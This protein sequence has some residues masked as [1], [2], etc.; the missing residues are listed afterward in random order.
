MI[1]LFICGDFRA[2]NASKIVVG[3]QL[4]SILSK[5]DYSICNFEAPVQSKG[6]P[7]RK[8]GPTLDQDIKSIDVLSDLGFNVVLLANN[9]IMDYGEEGCKATMQ[10]CHEN[11]ITYV[12]A[13]FAKEAYQVRVVEIS[14]LKIGFLSLVQHEFGVVESSDDPSLGTA[15]INSYDIEEVI[16]TA[17]PKVDYLFVLPHAGVEHI[18][19]PLPEWRRCYRKIIDW[20][21]DMIIASHPH[22]PQGWELYKDKFI[23]YSLGN[24]YFDELSGGDYWNKSLAV[25]ICID[26]DLSVNTHNLIFDQDG[27]VDIDET[28]ESKNH[29]DYLNR[30]LNDEKL[31]N[32]YIDDICESHYE[33]QKYG[34]LRGVCGFSI[35]MR[36]YYCLRLFVLMLM[37]NR[38]EMY[39]L[40]TLQNESH[41]WLIERCL[42]NREK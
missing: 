2:K 19:A 3:E 12:G 39:L 33:G 4:K 35:H 20:G 10:A 1:K 25:E 13:G 9:H 30:L 34:L 29:I 27:H 24:F 22:C 11:N 26:K 36:L 7:I 40:N 18:D 38:D 42:R 15:W 5:S 21:A 32:N 28:K 14:G 16:K 8:S 41:R 17:K 6:L 37:R 23:F 31:Y